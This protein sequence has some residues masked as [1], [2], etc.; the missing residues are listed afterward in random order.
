MIPVSTSV[1]IAK[2]PRRVRGDGPARLEVAGDRESFHVVF[3]FISHL[4]ELDETH[5]V[6]SESLDN[7]ISNGSHSYLYLLGLLTV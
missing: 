6:T 3:C 5:S 4:G 2:N 1:A 7:D